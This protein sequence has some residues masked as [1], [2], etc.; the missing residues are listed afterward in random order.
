MDSYVFSE[1][2]CF[3]SDKPPYRENL[4][5]LFFDIEKNHFLDEDG[6]RVPNIFEI[7]RPSDLEI[8]RHD[9]KW[10]LVPHVSDKNTAVELIWPE[11]YE[12]SEDIESAKNRWEGY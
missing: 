11:I 6:F 4:M 12:D 2:F 10:M 8:F 1:G 7:I 3:M 9:T 5:S